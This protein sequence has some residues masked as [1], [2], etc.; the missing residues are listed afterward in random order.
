MPQ[1]PTISKPDRIQSTGSDV[2][3]RYY[4]ATSAGKYV[5]YSRWS[6]RRFV[7]TGRIPAIH[8]PCGL[9]FTRPMLDR[10]LAEHN[11]KNIHRHK[12]S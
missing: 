7:R 1:E 4:T 10:F 2:T 6:M 8:T 12:S 9:I 3:G 5:G 11:R